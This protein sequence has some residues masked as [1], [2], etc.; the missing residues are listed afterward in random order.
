MRLSPYILLPLLL[1][2]LS[3]A[4]S[5]AGDRRTDAALARA[6]AAMQSAP[7]SALAI[8][9]SI[10]PAAISG[11]RRRALHA[12][13]L[14]QALDKNYIDTDNDSLINIAV[15]YYANDGD[16]N[17]RMLAYYYLGR[18][19]YNAKDYPSTM[20][21]YF[22]AFDIAKEQNNHF[23]AGLSAREI[24]QT[25]SETANSDEEI[26]YAKIAFEHMRL[27]GQHSHIC[28]SLNRLTQAL[29]DNEAN[30][31]CLRF[32]FE[33]LDSV[34]A[35]GVA[36][37]EYN[38]VRMIG[39]V[40]L[41]TERYNE[42]IQYLEDACCSDKA[43]YNDSCYLGLSYLFAG[44]D[45]K[46]MEI[47]DSIRPDVDIPG[48]WFWHEVALRHN[49]YK[50]AHDAL[51]KLNSHFD[52]RFNDLMHSG[53]SRLL[54]EHINTEKNLAQHS[55]NKAMVTKWILIISFVV[56]ISLIVTITIRHNRKQRKTIEA[57][58]AMAEELRQ[59]LSL[60]ES[61][62][63]QA[64]KSIEEL[65]STQY[66][67]ID[68]LCELCYQQR[69]NSTLRN[70]ISDEVTAT[71]KSLTSRGGKLDE[72]EAN[73]DKY[74]NRLISHLRSEMPELKKPDYLLVLFSTLGFSI[75]AITILLNE[76][77]IDAVYN[78][79]ARLKA[80][81]K[82]LNPPHAADFINVLS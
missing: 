16:I 10:D 23:W 14:S 57:N 79:K 45:S 15:D 20:L 34:K 58:N 28:S 9:D 2:L 70:R 60:K 53:F 11:Q 29:F 74:Y 38:A 6:E 49:N 69:D 66:E 33:L 39:K 61:Q 77:K 48:I 72:L 43:T 19:K 75:T 68:H 27:T 54:I 3:L 65:L 35:H 4:A 36:K 37:F 5:C 1:L 51:A 62:N 40:Y 52:K 63:A 25:Y 81:I 31:E 73:A 46:A 42:A 64:R 44:H 78:R 12:L 26:Y 59:I 71:I 7:D 82:K 24:S 17:R 41:A 47:F 22:K 50:S 55:Y 56:V 80:K 67:A 30:S 76:D 13:L 32:S 18:V 8:L 21:A